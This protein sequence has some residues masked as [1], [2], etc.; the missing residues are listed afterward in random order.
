MR[1]KNK[2]NGNKSNQARQNKELNHNMIF[3]KLL[4]LRGSKKIKLNNNEIQESLDEDC[5]LSG[6]SIEINETQH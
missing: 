4:S 6:S 1:K 3:V 5:I 2:D